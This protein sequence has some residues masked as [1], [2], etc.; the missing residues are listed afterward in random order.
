MT[1]LPHTV[2]I[3]IVCNAMGQIVQNLGIQLRGSRLTVAAIA[4]AVL[5]VSQFISTVHAGEHGFDAHTHGGEVC[6]F[7]LATENPTN[8]DPSSAALTVNFTEIADKHTFYSDT[9]LEQ[10]QRQRPPTRAPP[11]SL[12]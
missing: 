2:Q 11:L 5:L 7:A 1:A 3:P 4:I 8:T 6:E 12:S 9:A 10:S